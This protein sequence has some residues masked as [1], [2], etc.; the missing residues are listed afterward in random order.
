[1]KPF[2]N[3]FPKFHKIALI[4]LTL[5]S[6]GL[7]VSGFLVP[8]LGVIDGSVLTACGLLLAWGVVWLGCYSLSKGYDTTLKHGNT[9]LSIK[10]DDE[11]DEE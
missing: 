4:I 6:I 2:K 11:I 10:N 9:E 3:L 1:M 7:I 8:P 5:V